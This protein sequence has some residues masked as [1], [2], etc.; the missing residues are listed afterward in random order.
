MTKDSPRVT[1]PA[2]DSHGIGDAEVLVHSD[3]SVVLRQPSE[4]GSTALEFTPSEWAAFVAGAQAGEFD[5]PW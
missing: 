4:G 3:G 1:L 2:G 5:E